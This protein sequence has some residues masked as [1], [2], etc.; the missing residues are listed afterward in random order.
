MTGVQICKLMEKHYESLRERKLQRLREHRERQ[1][2]PFFQPGSEQDPQLIWE[3]LI[4][5]VENMGKIILAC[6]FGSQRYKC[7]EFCLKDTC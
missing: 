2:A 5:K 7:C 6:A 4:H 3:K 1:P